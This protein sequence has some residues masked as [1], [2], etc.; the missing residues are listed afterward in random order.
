MMSQRVNTK[1]RL[2]FLQLIRA[3]FDDYV[4][5]GDAGEY[6]DFYGFAHRRPLTEAAVWG[7]LMCHDLYV[8]RGRF[9][10]LG[11]P[12][13]KIEFRATEP[14]RTP[15]VLESRSPRWNAFLFS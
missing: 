9:A 7:S 2:V 13:A 3:P 1:S 10:A 11:L 6:L 5:G 14:R 4:L 15:G 8:Y 12:S